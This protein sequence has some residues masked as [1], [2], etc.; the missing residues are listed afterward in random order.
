M[1]QTIIITFCFSFSSFGLLAKI[2]EAHTIHQIEKNFDRLSTRSLL[3]WD[4][5]HTLICPKD[6]ILSFGNEALALELSMRHFKTTDNQK[7]SHL[8]S[9]IFSQSSY[10]LVNPKIAELISSIQAKG[11]PTMAFTAL[12]TG[13]FGN[14]E[15]LENMREHQLK[16][17]KID[18]TPFLSHCLSS[19]WGEIFFENYKPRF[20]N[21]ILYSDRLDKGIVFE[22]FFKEL[23]WQPDLIIFIDDTYQCLTSVGKI[24]KK[25]RIP[26]LG[27][28]YLESK[29]S[30]VQVNNDI[31]NLQYQI[32]SEKEIWLSDEEAESQLHSNKIIPK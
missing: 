11:I 26:Y 29:N 13:T 32:L 25:L 10:R 17:H 9:L 1:L 18:F 30:P 15:C 27:I 14:I 5:D 22:K 3:I 7:W 16:K 23:K 31:A 8:I 28:H 20:K 19:E 24:L 6:K 2:I 12:G 4:V 21:G